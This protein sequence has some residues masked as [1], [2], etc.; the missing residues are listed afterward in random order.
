MLEK[1]NS[2]PMTEAY[3]ISTM[4][5]NYFC[6]KECFNLA[7][8]LKA[9]M[10]IDSFTA[11]GKMLML[12]EV[13]V[14]TLLHGCSLIFKIIQGGSIWSRSVVGN[15]LLQVQLPVSQ[16]DQLRVTGWTMRQCLSCSSFES[17]V[18][19]PKNG[20]LLMDLRVTCS[21]LDYNTHQQ[22]HANEFRHSDSKLARFM[23]RCAWP[24]INHWIYHEGSQ[25]PG[26]TKYQASAK[27]WLL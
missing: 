27:H 1:L 9:C 5:R 22:A 11:L 14:N 20:L 25:F 2:C 18:T 13:Y 21:G 12:I 3:T 4:W 7:P 17:L 6:V 10:Y 26:R 23:S 16:E 8:C 19:G 24:E 15:S